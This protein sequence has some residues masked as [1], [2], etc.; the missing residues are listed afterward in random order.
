MDCDLLFTALEERIGRT[1]GLLRTLRTENTRLRRD[2]D[3][4]RMQT[5]ALAE[6]CERW[7]RERRALGQRVE[8]LL[9]ELDTLTL[10]DH[11]GTG[12]DHG[13]ANRLG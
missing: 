7:E 12:Y 9:L 5:T 2:L 11:E 3:E 13:L 1:L 4:A 8:R 10:H 6:R